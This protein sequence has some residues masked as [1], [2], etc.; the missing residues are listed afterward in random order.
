MRESAEA[1][2]RVHHEIR[3]V[4]LRRFPYAIYYRILS[5]EI[6]VLAVMHG[7]RQPRRWQSRR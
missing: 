7:R 4:R 2:A 5:D 6:V 3:R 1:F